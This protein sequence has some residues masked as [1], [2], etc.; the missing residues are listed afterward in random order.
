MNAKSADQQLNK[1]HN[2][3]F[4]ASFD[5]FSVILLKGLQRMAPH[6]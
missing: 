5:E 3:F 1:L 4:Q 2:D 6:T